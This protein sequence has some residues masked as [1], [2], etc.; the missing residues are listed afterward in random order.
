M[1]QSKLRILQINNHEQ[2]GGGS[3]R[4]FQLTTKLLLDKGHEV[5]S[6]SCGSHTFDERKSSVLLPHNGYIASNPL[7][8]VRNIRDFVYRPASVE[9]TRKLVKYFQP[10][11]AH[12]HI[13]YG[14][15]SSSVLNTLAELNIPC[16]MTVHE[17]RMLCPVS[18]LYTE[19]NGVCERCA[20][21]AKIH[22]LLGRCNRGSLLASG[23]SVFE[24]WFRD[25]FFPYDKLIAHFFMV[26]RFCL[27]KHAQYSS[28]IAS[29][30]SVLYNFIRDADCSAQ[31]QLVYSDA[32]FLYCGRMSR[33]K[34]VALLCDAFAQRPQLE[35]RIA[36][37]GPLAT[38][39]RSRY[40]AYPNIKFLGKLNS[41]E[42]KA[43]LA[44]A[45]FSIAPSEWYE[46]NP[47]AIL[48]SFALG[49]PVLGA[50]IGGIPELVM[51]E[52]TGYL[53]SPSDLRSL[54]SAL[55]KA[56]QTSSE[57]RYT[58]GQMAIDLIRDKHSEPGYY[59]QLISG[60]QRVLSH[61]I[62]SQD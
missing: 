1:H 6:I 50:A 12:L 62:R 36:G 51:P 45:R 39:L 30:S 53:F 43:E 19:R 57:Q 59:E 33:E 61:P 54:L 26:S 20:G 34:G 5:S 27:D 28:V 41:T 14:Q 15:L 9:A 13:F 55:D 25:R 38:E 3:E 23:I 56:T 44:A 11:I 35:L 18:T 16:V 2:V 48:E 40:S 17:Y 29:K 8:T 22:A 32:P 21:G 47:M 10:D 42:L 52:R 60:Y 49:T 31:P 46:N 24:S 37:A 58:M 7:K 4:V